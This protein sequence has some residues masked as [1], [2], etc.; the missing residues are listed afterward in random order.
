MT[1]TE[2]LVVGKQVMVNVA[3][4]RAFATFTE[5]FGAVRRPLH[6]ARYAAVLEDR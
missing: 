6:L 1:P 2:V 5:R 3:V 4:E